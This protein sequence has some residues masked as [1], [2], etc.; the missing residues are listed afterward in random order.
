MVKKIFQ[1]YSSLFQV[2]FSSRAIDRKPNIRFDNV[3]ERNGMET[4]KKFIQ[5][6]I[7]RLKNLSAELFRY[8]YSIDLDILPDYP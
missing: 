7:D 2:L 5:S 1:V 4:K 8:K 6:N 3:I